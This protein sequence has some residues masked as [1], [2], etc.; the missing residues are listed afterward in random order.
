MQKTN[1]EFIMTPKLTFPHYFFVVILYL[2]I[3]NSL[4]IY[5][6]PNPQLWKK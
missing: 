5:V 3:L 2:N 6:Q 4:I 1:I